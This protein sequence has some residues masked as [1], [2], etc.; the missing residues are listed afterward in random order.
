MLSQAKASP[1]HRIRWMENELKLFQF[2]L[3]ALSTLQ[4][5]IIS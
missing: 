3:L 1:Q 5:L 4:Q 2:A